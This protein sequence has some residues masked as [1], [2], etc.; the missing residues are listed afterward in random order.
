MGERPGQRRSDAEGEKQP[1]GGSGP[2][3]RRATYFFLLVFA[4]AA[5][6]ASISVAVIW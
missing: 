4:G 3:K 6:L 5:G 1:I 2:P